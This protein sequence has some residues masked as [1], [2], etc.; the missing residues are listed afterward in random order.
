MT[1]AVVAVVALALAGCPS[2]YGFR[3]QV[4]TATGP[5]ELIRAT[6]ADTGTS[7]DPLVPVPGAQVTCDGCGGDAP[8]ALDA[9]GRFD[10]LLSGPHRVVL[11]VTAPGY[12][13]VELEIARP[14]S[15]SQ[16]GMGTFLIVLSPSP[17]S[18]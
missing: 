8:L 5:V 14:P 10:V 13:A 7:W 2:S 16:A 17:P 15:I 9:A 12:Q 6:G 1:R 3:G 18:P 4:T 11:R